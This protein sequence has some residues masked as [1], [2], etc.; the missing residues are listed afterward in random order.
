MTEPMV[1]SPAICDS[2]AILNWFI[3]HIRR[4]QMV[5]EQIARWRGGLGRLRAVQ[6]RRAR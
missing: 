5:L 4:Y 6:S 2:V 1:G 3:G